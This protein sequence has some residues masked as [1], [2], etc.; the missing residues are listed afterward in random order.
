MKPLFAAACLA[1][2][3]TACAAP[4]ATAGAPAPVAATQADFE[5]DRQSIYAMAGTFKVTFDMRET[6]PFVAG[7]T[8]LEPKLSGGHE[9]VRVI[10][11][12]GRHIVLQHLL[13]ADDGEGR[14]FVIKHWR[15]DWAYEPETVLTYAGDSKWT[16]SPVSAAD[17][18]RAW[19][20]TVWQ[21]DDSPRYGGVGRWVYDGGD[22]RWTSDETW[23]P[24]ARRDA[25]RHPP[26][27]RY[28]GT[29]RHAITPAGWIHEQD[30][31]KLGPVN[32][33]ETTYVH[34][35][36]LNTY[37]RFDRFDVAKADNYWAKSKDYWAR[38]RA[39]WDR[40]IAAQGGVTV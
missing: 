6:A 23:R 19:S 14:V 3:L 13:V 37:R 40:A 33:V 16:T 11:D 20:Q 36:V 26:Y 22:A 12:T 10:E 15:Q 29:N 32:S 8:P 9:V 31:A 28:R 7:Y 5:R 38:V 25:V 4:G 39:M 35:T 1:L 34:E 24:L 30:N 21:V 17:R 27:D 2:S 18:A